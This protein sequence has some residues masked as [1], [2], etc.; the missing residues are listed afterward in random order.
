M[1]VCQSVLLL[2]VIPLLRL[3]DFLCQVILL[4]NMY[5]SANTF[6]VCFPVKSLPVSSCII[7]CLD[8]K[9]SSLS[10]CTNLQYLLLSVSR[11]SDTFSF[12]FYSCLPVY[13]SEIKHFISKGFSREINRTACAGV[14][15]PILPHT[16]IRIYHLQMA[17]V[18][19]QRNK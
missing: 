2:L 18:P 5:L 6:A 8:V 7:T 14:D 1:L 15:R 13:L 17:T 9:M 16:G 11:F 3:C 4:S 12:S 10:D 19:R